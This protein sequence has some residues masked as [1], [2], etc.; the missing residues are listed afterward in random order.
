MSGRRGNQ[1][2]KLEKPQLVVRLRQGQG[3]EMQMRLVGGQQGSVREEGSVQ[4]LGSDD[5]TLRL[6]LDGGQLRRV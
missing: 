5:G 6:S 2:S 1:W 3:W 4:H